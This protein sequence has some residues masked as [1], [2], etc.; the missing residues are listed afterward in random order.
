[1]SYRE[2]NEQEKKAINK[3]IRKRWTF[4][5]ATI[6]IAIQTISFHF[7]WHYHRLPFF[8]AFS[9][10]FNNAPN[11]HESHAIKPTNVY[12]MLLG[13]VSQI[14]IG[15]YLTSWLIAAIIA[16]VIGWWKLRH[17]KKGLCI[18]C[19]YDLRMHDNQCPE[20]GEFQTV[21]YKKLQY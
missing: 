20:C 17:I 6:H 13:N 19:K 1:M 11:M 5:L 7:V 4:W 15:G 12:W 10:L 9:N 2:P 21:L 14:I 18:K 3:R 16:E 8:I